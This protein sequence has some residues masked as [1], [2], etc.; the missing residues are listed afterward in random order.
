MKNED[1]KTIE[2]ILDNFDFEKVITVMKLLD[3]KWVS[4]DGELEIPTIGILYRRSRDL[5]YDL[6]NEPLVHQIFQGGFCAR[7]ETF[8]WKNYYTLSF[9]V[10]SWSN[11]E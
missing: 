8:D 5:L 3:W 1:R 10:T 7:R 4:A 11:Y 2:C 9:E 6:A